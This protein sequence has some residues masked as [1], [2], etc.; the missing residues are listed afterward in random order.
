MHGGLSGV[1]SALANLRRPYAVVALI[2]GGK[3]CHRR[4]RRWF[5][6][7]VALDVSRKETA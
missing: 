6:P 1:A 3:Q 2:T 7:V 5:P 4:L